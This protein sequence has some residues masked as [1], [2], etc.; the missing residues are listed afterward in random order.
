MPLSQ[1]SKKTLCVLPEEIIYE[2]KG[3]HA[4]LTPL[5]DMSAGR[6]QAG[7]GPPQN[8]EKVF[9][10]RDYSEGT[11]VKFQTRF[12]T[13]LESRLDRQLFEYTINQLNNYF[14]EAERASCSTYCESCLYCLTDTTAKDLLFLITMP[15]EPARCCNA[16]F[17]ERILPNKRVTASACDFLAH[18]SAWR[19]RTEIVQKRS[20]RSSERKMRSKKERE[21]TIEKL[22]KKV[23]REVSR[24]LIL[25]N[26]A[27]SRA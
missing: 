1:S 8:C 15:A 11:M 25:W 26:V 13:E 20:P 5:E 22:Q 23:S 16:M 12:P 7:G 6:G 14:A 4:A 10:Q 24:Q 2:R 9:I 3:N 21:K 19:R 17:A 27:I 18:M